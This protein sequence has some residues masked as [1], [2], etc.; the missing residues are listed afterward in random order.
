VEIGL[1]ACGLLAGREYLWDPLSEEEKHQVGHW[2]ATNRATGHVWNNHFYFGVMALEFLREVGMARPADVVALD[3][4]FK[5]MEGM[6]RGHGWFMDGINQSY[7]HYNSYAFHFYG[8][9]WGHLF[10]H[11]NPERKE[12]WCNWATEFLEEYQYMFAASG[13]HPAFGRSITYRFNA[14]APFSLACLMGVSPLPAGR[15]RRLC[16]R[17]LEFFLNKPIYQEQGAV[18]I[19]W[20]DVFPELSEPYSC[21]GS[22]YWSAKAFA[23]LLLPP[24]HEFW[25][26]SEEPLCSEQGDFVRLQPEAGLI[27]RGI[28]G[29]VEILNGGSEITPVNMA[30]FGPWKWG[31]AAYRTG[32][33]FQIG[34]HGEY[35]LKAAGYYSKDSGLTMEGGTDTRVHGRHYTLPFEFTE[36]NL[37]STYALGD[38]LE[39]LTT[40]VESY[41]WWK[42][43]WLLQVHW[44]DSYQED[45]LNH[46]GYAIASRDPGEFKKTEG[47]GIWCVTNGEL[48]SSLQPLHG[49]DAGMGWD[50]RLDDS[51]PRSHVQAPYHMTPYATTTTAKGER[52]TAAL[53]YAGKNEAEAGAWKIQSGAAGHWVLE[54]PILGDWKISHPMLPA[55]A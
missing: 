49:F 16:T 23:C 2:I 52:L 39:Q 40:V 25:T 33:G 11:S 34:Q 38:K 15:A 42:K 50:Q 36:S 8:L 21:A 48:F 20:H 47:S 29:E 43:G 31:K 45:K 44:T 30:K 3:V 55:L 46:G 6:Y 18:G 5:E 54:H 53:A 17:N 7:D 13:E 12:R 41:V 35:F 51:V 32:V 24:D 9:L 26:A 28:D 37:A 10:G 19:G 27:I 22:V 14:S 4:W 1:L